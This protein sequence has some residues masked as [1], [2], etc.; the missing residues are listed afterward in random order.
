MR[1]D[2]VMFIVIIVSICQPFSNWTWFYP[3]LAHFWNSFRSGS[4]TSLPLEN[5][6]QWQHNH[7]IEK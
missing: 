3:V 5:S 2:E 6:P 7:S 4:F 1:I